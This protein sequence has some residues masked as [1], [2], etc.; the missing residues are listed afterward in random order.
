MALARQLIRQLTKPLATTRALRRLPEYFQR[1]Y[2]YDDGVFTIDDFDGNL[3]YQSHFSSHIG[4]HVFWSGCYARS[5]LAL[6][7]RLLNRGDMVVFDVGANEGEETLFAAKRVPNGRVF[8]FEPNPLVRARLRKNVELN[9]FDN[10]SIQAIGLDAQPGKLVLYG[11]SGRGGDGTWNAGQGS[12]FPR[13][14]VDA[15]IG[16]IS[17][18]TLDR[19]VAEQSIPQIDLIKIDVEGAELN[20]LRG[21]ERVL[22]EHH[23]NMIVEVWE[24]VERSLELLNYIVGKNYSIRNIAADG[25]T[26]P[27]S[28]LR[29]TTRDVL[30]VF[31]GG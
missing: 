20:V 29:H 1:R 2:S 18:S 19:F 23:P 13:S 14:G 9:G 24:G 11:P 5:V 12:I 26:S 31:N 17:L 7:Q 4:S 22:A 6:L 30:C 10:V 3:H 15:P 28:D 25:S 21:G 27:A 8:S 16:E